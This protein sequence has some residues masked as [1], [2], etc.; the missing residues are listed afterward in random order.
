MEGVET[1]N[2]SGTANWRLCALQTRVRNADQQNGIQ[3]NAKFRMSTKVR[4]IFAVK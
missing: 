1:T 4:V 3:T 2:E